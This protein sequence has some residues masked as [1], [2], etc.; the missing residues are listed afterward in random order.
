MGKSIN[1]GTFKKIFK[2]ITSC[3]TIEHVQTTGAW[4]ERLKIPD[5]ARLAFSELLTLQKFKIKLATLPLFGSV[6]G[7]PNE[8]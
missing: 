4:L 7:T 2:T 6:A 8:K 5:D 1:G 3:K